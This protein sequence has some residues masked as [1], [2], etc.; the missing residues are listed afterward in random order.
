M[1]KDETI[2]KNL[3]IVRQRLG[4]PLTLAEK[5]LYGHLADAENETLEPGEAYTTNMWLLVVSFAIPI[6]GLLAGLV[7]PR[8]MNFLGGSKSKTAKLQIEQ[9]MRKPFYVPENVYIIGDCAKDADIEGTF[10]GG[11]PPLPSIQIARAFEK[12]TKNG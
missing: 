5:V 12:H 2:R 7:G 10:I 6:L 11:C 1:D 8:V 3:E 4:R 9:L